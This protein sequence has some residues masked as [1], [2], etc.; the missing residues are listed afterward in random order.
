[1][2]THVE[3]FKEWI[4]TIREDI[5]LLE[6][7]VS[8]DSIERDARTYAAAALNYLVTRM[9]L[10][11]DWEESIGILDDAMV[12]RICVE[13]ASQNGLDSGLEDADH[14]VALGRLVNEVKVVADFLGKEM[15]SDLREYCVKLTDA[16]VR[17]R[18]TATIL[19]S[20]EERTKLFAEVDADLK[21]LPPA[22]FSDPDAIELKFKSYL[23]HKLTN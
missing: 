9:D 6:F 14:I 23:K 5:G 10:V 22:S 17:G 7:I 19:E 13:L 20:E 11:P 15:H 18:G 1:M 16:E 12:L 21:R 3:N 8:T 4:S 2:S